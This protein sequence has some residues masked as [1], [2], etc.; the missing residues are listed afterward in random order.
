[1]HINDDLSVESEVQN[2][3]DQTFPALFSTNKSLLTQFR[4]KNSP[5]PHQR[6]AMNFKY[7]KNTMINFDKIEQY[8]K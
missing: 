3:S 2:D 6:M 7:K 1:M 5:Q 8:N 4:N